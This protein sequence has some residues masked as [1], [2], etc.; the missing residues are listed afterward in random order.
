ME[1]GISLFGYVVILGLAQSMSTHKRVIPWRVIIGGTVLQFLF[2]FLTLK[3][4]PGLWLFFRIG[5]F[6]TAVPDFVEVGASFVF[7]EVFRV[8]FFA[9]KVLPT[10]VFFS[11]LSLCRTTS[12]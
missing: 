12:A 4:A 3:T 10:I 9:F 6:F 8:H 2:A 7:G 5:D 11:S 1:R